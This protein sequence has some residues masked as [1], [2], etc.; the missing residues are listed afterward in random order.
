MGTPAIHEAI[1]SRDNS[2]TGRDSILL[3]IDHRIAQFYP[4]SKFVWF[5]MFN[6]FFQEGERGEDC[7]D[8]FIRSSRG[9]EMALVVDPPFGGFVE[10]LAQ[11]LDFIFDKISRTRGL[12]QIPILLC[13]P[14]FLS[15]FVSKTLPSLKM[16]E[17]RVQY[18]N[19]S[20][21]K[22]TSSPVRIFTNIALKDFV[23]P[24]EE[25]YKFC[26]HC[27][28]SVVTGVTHCHKCKSCTAFGSHAAVHCPDCS[29][30]VKPF[31]KHCKK[32]SK[33]LPVTHQHA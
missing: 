32:C 22:K 4:R 13:L 17:Y 33:C 10:L 3:D 21:Y 6:H 31:L 15:S 12:Q 23:L 2:S 7:L 11:T 5:N 25:G 18:T 20:K 29:R 8:K 30:C 19:H 24:A 14:F 27:K 16:S 1:Q 28:K 9:E 26:P